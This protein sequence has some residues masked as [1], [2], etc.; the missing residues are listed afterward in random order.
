ML[1]GPSYPKRLTTDERR[2]RGASHRRVFAAEVRRALDE[3]G[4]TASRAAKLAGVS[5]GAF[6]AWLAGDVDPDPRALRDVGMVVGRSHL[7]LAHLVGYLPDIPSSSLL[8]VDGV[9]RQRAA[10]RELLRVIRATEEPAGA[11]GSA[12]VLRALEQKSEQWE[13]WQVWF[14]PEHRGVRHKSLFLTN[15]AFHQPGATS[16]AKSRRARQ[17][18]TMLL[19]DVFPATGAFWRHRDRTETWSWT[20]PNRDL[21]LGIPHFLAPRA[22]AL[23]PNPGVRHPI[24][25]AGLPYSGG[26]NVASILSSLLGWSFASL[27]FAAFRHYEWEAGLPDEHGKGELVPEAISSTA[28]AQ[29]DLAERYL[30]SSD[31]AS[32]RLVWAFDDPE[33]LHRTLHLLGDT[34]TLVIAPQLPPDLIAYAAHR[35][36]RDESVLAEVQTALEATLRDRSDPTTYLL[37]PAEAI[38]VDMTATDALDDVHATFD[39]WA[40]LAMAAATWLHEHHGGPEVP[41]S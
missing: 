21:V 10:A 9:N 24:C 11:A 2:S 30:K 16:P 39:A 33:A 5:P 6:N 26:P 34:S 29:V 15:V 1:R 18:L 13:R 3:Q 17:E 35:T 27:A 7:R 37:L 32:S 14:Q 19:G 40:D 36:G 41:E 31:E 4:L 20:P 12:T 25:V 38:P 23:H 22:E 28:S 8:V